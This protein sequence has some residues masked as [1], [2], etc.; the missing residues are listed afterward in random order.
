MLHLKTTDAVDKFHNALL[1]VHAAPAHI[2]LACTAYCFSRCLSRRGLIRPSHVTY[3]RTGDQQPINHLPAI[4]DALVSPF[5]ECHVHLQV[6]D[7]PAGSKLLL[8]MEFMEGGPVLT[9]EALETQEKLP[10]Q[11][12]VQYFRDMVKVCHNTCV[13]CML[14]GSFLCC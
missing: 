10:E 3:I 4:G 13:I 1:L 6:I 14:A 2:S 9:R 11:L 7:D 5:H 12:A 8:V